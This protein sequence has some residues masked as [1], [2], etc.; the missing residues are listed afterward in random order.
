MTD[1]FWKKTVILHDP[2]RAKD[3]QL[4][5]P[6]SGEDPANLGVVILNTEKHQLRVATDKQKFSI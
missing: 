3:A 4:K 1:I 5:T 2:K 6:V